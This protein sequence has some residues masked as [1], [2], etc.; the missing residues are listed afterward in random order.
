M[1]EEIIIT[2]EEMENSARVLRLL[3]TNEGLAE[4]K[5]RKDIKPEDVSNGLRTA[6]VIVTSLI[7]AKTELIL[8]NDPAAEKVE[9][10]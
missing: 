7:E 10:K 2:T 5:E 9:L 1:P 4:L 3:G 6:W 8:T